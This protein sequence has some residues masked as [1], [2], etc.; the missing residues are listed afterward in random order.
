VLL[1]YWL[2]ISCWHRRVLLMVQYWIAL[3]IFLGLVESISWFL[4]FLIANVDG[5]RNWPAIETAILV[6]TCKR[7]LSRVLVLIV[8]MGYGVVKYVQKGV[9]RRFDIDSIAARRYHLGNTRVKVYLMGAG[10]F[11][12]SGIQSSVEIMSREGETNEFLSFIGTVVI[13]PVI[14]L[15]TFFYWWIF[16]SI[17]KTI[18]QLTARQASVKL[19]LYKQFFTVL[20]CAAVFTACVMIVELYVSLPTSSCL[21]SSPSLIFEHTHTHTQL[22]SNAAVA[23]IIV[24][25]RMDDYCMLAWPLLCGLDHD[26]HPV[27]P[28]REQHEIRLH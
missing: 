17:M 7:T 8:S 13:F 14:L 2:G 20:V 1:M 21:T 3:V 18:Q 5:K 10:Y 9:E 26:R 23:R 6:S 28:D 12:A 15:D 25:E 24:D 4:E 27:A 19:T 22:S 16:L 11:V